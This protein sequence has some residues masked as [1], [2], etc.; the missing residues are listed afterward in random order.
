MPVLPAMVSRMARLNCDERAAAGCRH[1]VVRDQLA[2]HDS[3]VV[4]RF[5]YA[6]D[7]MDWLIGW[8]WPQEFDCVICGDG[9]GRMIQAEAFHQMVSSGPVAMTVEHSARDAA[10]QHSRKRFL[11]TFCLPVSDNFITA[12]K[13][14]DVQPF[15]V[16]RSTTKT[17]QV[18]RIRLLNAFHINSPKSNVQSPKSGNQCPRSTER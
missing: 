7:K 6:R 2:F 13:A 9:A 4:R 8:S 11:V 16:C 5:N 1:F 18:W 12:G 3:T 10:T 17:L 15:F 14:A